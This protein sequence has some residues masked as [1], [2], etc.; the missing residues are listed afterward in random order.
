M[1]TFAVLIPTYNEEYNVLSISK[2]LE[3]ID[4]PFL[5]VD[6]GSIDKTV[7]VL[8]FKDLPYL[9]YFPNRGKAYALKLGAKYLFKEG[10]EYIVTIDGDRQCAIEDIE[11]FDNALL[12]YPDCDIIIGNRLW[13]KKHMPKIRFYTN[14]IMSWI[15]SKLAGVKIEDT[16]CGFR[17]YSKRIFETLDLKTNGFTMESEV[18]IKA[19][20]AGYK[21]KSIPIKCIYHK[22]RKSNIKIIRDFIRF[23]KLIIHCLQINN[24]QTH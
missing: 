8:W 5:F 23:V 16:Q 10:Y 13:D 7:T 3:L 17:L 6:D 11:K 22:G 18:L 19:G 2:D 9:A 4:V 1:E 21:I 12:F 14:K 20:K 24:K 15:I